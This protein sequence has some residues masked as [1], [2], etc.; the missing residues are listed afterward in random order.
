MNEYSIMAG[1]TTNLLRCWEKIQFII[2]SCAFPGSGDIGSCCKKEPIDLEVY[3]VPMNSVWFCIIYVY[4]YIFVYLY[5]RRQ[6]IV[7]TAVLV[8]NKIILSRM[9]VRHKSLFLLESAIAYSGLSIVFPTC[10]MLLGS[11]NQ[12]I[13]EGE[14][15]VTI[16]HSTYACED[17]YCAL[18]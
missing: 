7:R 5:R 13:R 10:N 11:R 14:V 9:R 12:R 2:T 8:Q 16:I 3:G 4:A 17:H 1:A 6:A 15:V 18:H